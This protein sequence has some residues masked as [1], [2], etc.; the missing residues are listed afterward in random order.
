[1]H[2]RHNDSRYF[3][4]EKVDRGHQR[5]RVIEV[6]ATTA[7]TRTIIDEKTNTFIYESRLFTHYLPDTDEMLM[8]SEKDGWRHIYLFDLLTGKEIRQVTKGQWVVRDIDSIDTKK[9]EIC[10]SASVMNPD[11]DPYYLHC[12]RFGFDG[13]HLFNLTPLKANHI[14]TFSPD[15]NIISTPGRRSMFPP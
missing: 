1:M 4:Y 2:W 5:F 12:Y 13:Q 9:K 3:T 8:T 11:E 14:V 15:K 6:D 7:A 10:F